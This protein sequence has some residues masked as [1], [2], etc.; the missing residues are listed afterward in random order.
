MFKL[1]IYYTIKESK[2]D[3]YVVRKYI[4]VKHNYDIM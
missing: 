4:K 3:Y 1:H 2:H